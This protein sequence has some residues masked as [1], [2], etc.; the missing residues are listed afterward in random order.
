TL[1]LLA[2][3]ERSNRP[4]ALITVDYLRTFRHRSERHVE[5]PSITWPTGARILLVEDNQ[6]SQEVGLAV[7]SNINLPSSVAANGVEAIQSLKIAPDNAP[8][9]LVLMDCQM[10]EMDGFE[11]TCQIRAGAAGERNRQIKI[12][13][14]TAD[15]TINIKDRCLSAGM[16]DYLL[17]P[18]EKA[19]LID[20]ISIHLNVSTDRT[21]PAE[22][23]VAD[24][25]L[26]WDQAAALNIVGNK[27]S[28]LLEL[29]SI[30][31]KTTPPILIELGDALQAND[32]VRLKFAAHA[33]KGIAMTFSAHQ[34]VLAA[35]NLE[36]AVADEAAS[37]YKPLYEVLEEAFTTFYDLL[38]RTYP[39]AFE[40]DGA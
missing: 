33:L 31:H 35:A 27:E 36:S 3:L 9:S 20:L 40:V 8:Y 19:S 10:P 15:T 17:K 30:F 5:P 24:N 25:T 2:P 21:Q 37:T 38:Q 23:V 1:Q 12:I 14:M 32:S 22:P 6:I 4:T 13:A 28:R 34:L 29:I 18:V 39:V 16:D 26:I 7:L 11:A